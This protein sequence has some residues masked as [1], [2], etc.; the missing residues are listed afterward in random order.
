MN[1]NSKL[2]VEDIA[3]DIADEIAGIIC[4]ALADDSPKEYAGKE[5]K[6]ELIEAIYENLRNTL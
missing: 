3:D 4:N 6:E 1:A 5:D 2:W